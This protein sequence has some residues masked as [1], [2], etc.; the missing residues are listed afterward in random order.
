MLGDFEMTTPKPP[1][2][3]VIGYVSA[4]RQSLWQA[5]Y[6][7]PL[8]NPAYQFIT[9]MIEQTREVEEEFTKHRRK[10]K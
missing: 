9:D 3:K 10:V 1:E 2:N 8:D 6:W 7:C 5:Q 4:A